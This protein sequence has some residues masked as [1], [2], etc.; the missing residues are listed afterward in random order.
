[1]SKAWAKGSTS[2][3]R[4]IRAAV[5]AAN[6]AANRGRCQA[7]V[8]GVCTGQADQV[9]HPHGKGNQPETI[10]TLQA[11]CGACNRHIGDPTTGNPRP[12]RVTR[13]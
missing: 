2:R 7:A 1:V 8:P 11:V 10:D 6:Q 9:H 12:K 3:W 4:R 13:W 5:L